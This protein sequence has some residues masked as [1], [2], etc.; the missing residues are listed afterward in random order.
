VDYERALARIYENLDDD[1]V[2]KATM[3]CLRIARATKDIV[4]AATFA[5]ELCS[6]KREAVNLLYDDLSQLN[7]NARTLVGD[8]SG[9]RWLET[10]TLDF[11]LYEGSPADLFETAR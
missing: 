4:N 11:Y 7:Q 8:T 10:H 3:G 2:E 1:H 9:R 5:R 6:D